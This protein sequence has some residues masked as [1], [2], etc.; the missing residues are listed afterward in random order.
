M[1]ALGQ[2]HEGRIYIGCWHENSLVAR[3]TAR[4]RV[5]TSLVAAVQVEWMRVERIKNVYIGHWILEK[6]RLGHRGLILIVVE[7]FYFTC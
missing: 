4:G 1:L 2:V 3:Q 7:N 6:I 5:Y